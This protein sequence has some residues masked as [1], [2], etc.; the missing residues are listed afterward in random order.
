MARFCTLF[1]GSSGNCA[2]AGTADGGV[3]IDVGKSC[4]QVMA[5]LERKNIPPRAVR[6][7]LITHEHSDHVSGLRV[8]QKKLSVPVYATP[9]V[10]QY[11]RW[12]KC[13]EQ[14]APIR[15]IACGTVY[16][17]D[18]VCFSCFDT[19]HDSVHSV[20][21]RL[22]TSD[23]RAMAVA[24]DIG[25]ID[26][27]II[28]NLRGC[29]CV[30]LESNYDRGMLSVCAYPYQLKQRIASN[31][32]HLSNDDCAGVLCELARNGTTRFLLGHLSQNA[33][34]PIL[35]RQTALNAFF[36]AGMREN[37]DFQLHVAPRDEP[38]E[39]MLL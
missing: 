16:E 12:H 31:V 21:Y 4:R 22:Q 25:Y 14:C 13:V 32:G 33:N 9:E 24:T 34:L 30:L 38:S 37:V 39:M 27:S 17:A 29:D 1:S 10:A 23:G 26:D 35:A 15:E 2:Y 5:A 7:I 18:A 8:L 11:L 6:A 20:G 28:E 36:S 19:P 3:L